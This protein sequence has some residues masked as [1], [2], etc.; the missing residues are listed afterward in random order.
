MGKDP[1]VL[2]YTSDFLSGVMLMSM[3]ERGQFITL[4]CLQRERGHLSEKDM[5]KAV[6]ALSDELRKKFVADE[7][8]LFYNPRM[9]SEIRKR[10]AHAQKQRENVMRRWHPEG[11][12]A[13]TSLL[14][15]EPLRSDAENVP[16][17]HFLNAPTEGE[18]RG[19]E[20]P[21]QSAS[22][23][24]PP[25]GEPRKAAARATAEEEPRHLLYKDVSS[26]AQ[27]ASSQNTSSL[28]DQKSQKTSQNQT[29]SLS[30]R[31]QSGNTTVLPFGNGNWF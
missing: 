4:L 9:E 10:Q 19:V 27:E 22:L 8:G 14:A 7:N 21:S 17:A 28:T 20:L 3:K 13:P 29:N 30:A 1:A 25:E 18:P 15:A 2:F 24:A 16:P 12:H 26:S 6:G 5:K 11:E 31:G 23:T